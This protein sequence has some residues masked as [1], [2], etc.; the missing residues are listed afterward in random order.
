MDDKFIFLSNREEDMKDK[1]M[2][3]W[4]I[5][6]DRYFFRG[7]RYL[8]VNIN[9]NFEDGKNLASIFGRILNNW[10]VEKID[11][12][13]LRVG[14]FCLEAN[15]NVYIFYHLLNEDDDINKY[16]ELLSDFFSSHSITINI[17]P[18][19]K[20]L[21][22]GA[23]YDFED[24]FSGVIEFKDESIQKI[25]NNIS[26]DGI[27]KFSKKIRA[28][29]DNFMDGFKTDTSIKI[30]QILSACN[31][32]PVVFLFIK[33]HDKIYPFHSIKATDKK[34]TKPLYICLLSY[35]YLKKLD[36][37]IVKKPKPFPPDLKSIK[38]PILFTGVEDFFKQDEGAAMH[39]KKYYDPRY[40]FFDSSIW[41]RYIPIIN[42]G[43]EIG[44]YLVEKEKNDRYFMLP[45]AKEFR[46]FAIR[47]FNESYIQ[48][49]NK[50]GGHA[51]HIAP[52][53]FHSESKIKKNAA[54]EWEMIKE[55]KWKILLIDDDFSDPQEQNLKF[56]LIKKLLNINS[57][58]KHIS[59]CRKKSINEGLE[60]LREKYDIILLDY[61]F[62]ASSQPDREE[63]FGEE[64]L[65]RLC[66]TEG[67][68]LKE[69]Y[70]GPTGKFWIFP[71]SVY[72]TALVDK[73]RDNHIP[74][75]GDKW[76][77]APGADPLNTPYLFQYMLFNF[78]RTQLMEFAVQKEH[79]LSSAL[80]DC[81]EQFL[82]KVK[83]EKSPMDFIQKHILDLFP[84]VVELGVKFKRLRERKPKY[85]NFSSSVIQ[86]F[87]FNLEH[88]DWDHF[89]NL[90]YLVGY[91]NKSN[92]DQVWNELNYLKIKHE[93]LKSNGGIDDVYLQILESFIFI[94]TQYL[95]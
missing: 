2:P 13:N 79:I 52:Y 45:E 34:G 1:R 32:L 63:R 90:I 10:G 73:L 76:V 21:P 77:I 33:D 51:G 43:E 18:F 14:D 60:Q 67:D 94:I 35:D 24:I 48:K 53:G 83:A 4:K 6:V 26:Y 27:T 28:E 29:E 11:A 80:G 36:I 17:Y 85:Q 49:I 39:L 95:A 57:E 42:L 38:H 62:K 5:E 64:F 65:I 56:N 40:R 86:N 70:M 78:M 88:Y 25:K 55:F 89:Q 84:Q 82:D 23:C 75:Y 61:Y 50:S 8:A 68:Y 87:F 72:S 59:L 41:F 46:E 31:G 92:A 58:R 71:V 81:L 9:V 66:S 30:S 12:E 3:F 47:Q 20:G 69:S 93:Q 22:T 15:D 74:W 44:E 16:N 7:Y 37:S 91:G 54:E 19:S